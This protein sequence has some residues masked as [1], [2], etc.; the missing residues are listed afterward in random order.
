MYCLV[1]HTQVHALLV[2]RLSVR[3]VTVDLNLLWSDGA[4]LNHGHV[5]SLVES[6]CHVITTAAS[7]HVILVRFYL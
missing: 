5:A 2:Q 7:L 4:V 3:H 1:P 6:S